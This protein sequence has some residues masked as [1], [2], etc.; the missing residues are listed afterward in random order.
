MLRVR[1]LDGTKADEALW[2]AYIARASAATIYHDI[3]WRQIFGSSFGYK[4]HYLVAEDAAKRIHGVLPLFL[5]PA[6]FG[7]PKLVSVPFRDRGGPLFDDAA[8]L[9]ALIGQ[10]A[11]LKAEIGAAC[12]ELKSLAPYPILEFDGL[13][14]RRVDYWVHS[15][16]TLTDLSDERLL[17][18]VGDKTRNMIRQAERAGLR[19]VE[20]QAEAIGEWYRLHQLSQRGLG[21]PPF[22]RPFFDMIFARLGDRKRARL[23]LVLGSDDVAIAGCIVF[24]DRKSAIYAYSASAPADRRVRPNDFMLFQV[25]RSMLREEFDRFDFGSDSPD[26]SGLL[27][28]KRKWLAQQRVIP[29]Y[30]IAGDDQAPHM[31]D[32]SASRYDLPRRITR[33]LPLPLAQAILAPLVRYFG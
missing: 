9:A 16:A 7:R 33:Q 25:L 8:A 14:V 22:P 2:Q 32:S 28:F 27:F 17:K 31:T 24:E 23:F 1:A 3:A 12:V 15:E 5:V 29:R 13:D 18:I 30:Y 10:A 19:V 4:S 11:R 20:K 21:L 26:Q 6:L